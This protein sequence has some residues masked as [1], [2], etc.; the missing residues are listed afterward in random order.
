MSPSLGALLALWLA[1]PAGAHYEAYSPAHEHEDPAEAEA[2]RRARYKEALLR[3]AGYEQE[4]SPEEMAA[5]LAPF[6]LRASPER[7]RIDASIRVSLQG[8]GSMRVDE[9]SGNILIRIDEANSRPMTRLEVIAFLNSL[10]S[11]RGRRAVERVALNSASG[12]PT[13]QNRAVIDRMAAVEGPQLPPELLEAIRTAQAAQLL[14]RAAPVL[15][16]LLQAAAPAVAAMADRNLASNAESALHASARVF[17]QSRGLPAL[18]TAALPG[19]KDAPRH[20]VYFDAA[21]RRL[22]DLL[23]AEFATLLEGSPVGDELLTGLARDMPGITLI[24]IDSNRGGGGYGLPAAFYQPA[25]HSVTLLSDTVYERLRARALELGVPLRVADSWSDARRM[26]AFL[27]INDPDDPNAARAAALRSFLVRDQQVVLAHEFTHAWQR[28]RDPVFAEMLRGN[29]GHIPIEY[30]HE[31][32]LMHNRQFHHM[33]RQA[34]AR[35]DPDELKALASDPMAG[36][37]ASFLSDPDRFVQSITSNYQGQVQGATG[38][39]DLVALQRMRVRG[40]TADLSSALTMIPQA[41]MAGIADAW[42]HLLRLAGMSRGGAALTESTPRHERYMAAFFGAEG[43]YAGMRREGLLDMARLRIAAGDP[44]S[45][46]SWLQAARGAAQ[47]DAER[48]RIDE[49]TDVTTLAAARMILS[50]KDPISPAVLRASFGPLTAYYNGRG[51]DP[52][53]RIEGYR[54]IAALA[55]D[56]AVGRPDLRFSYLVAAANL[57]RGRGGVGALV[58]DLSAAE[59][60]L[61]DG[62][63]LTRPAPF[64]LQE[65][66]RLDLAGTLATYYDYGNV[67]AE[68]RPAWLAPLLTERSGAAQAYLDR[69][70]AQPAGSPER[71]RLLGLAERFL[72]FAPADRTEGLRGRLGELRRPM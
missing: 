72:P 5:L 56:P 71:A 59:A 14:Q 15:P 69:A 30:E 66:E 54:A 60:A 22:G 33:L 70:A 25:S 16:P 61:R 65:H 36:S 1:F 19:E 28:V 43:P 51:M 12:S 2:D 31:A 40:A 52:A 58:R 41:P 46:V 17:D 64:P 55:A 62:S 45:A 35:G 23:T 48:R 47:N 21:E 10:S 37:Y 34:L 39:Q 7:D 26:V 63:W 38:F 13:P 6:D 68:R 20:P 9:A 24:G 49:L 42:T 18:A 32:F 27:A 67:P 44:V 11:G 29:L 57:A 50:P 8:T 3:Q 4:P 53:V